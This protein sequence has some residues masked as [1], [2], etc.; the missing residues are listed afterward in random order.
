MSLPRGATPGAVDLLDE[1]LE[2]V[3]RAWGAVGAF[4]L[5]ALPSRVAL[6][7]LLLLATGPGRRWAPLLE[8]SYL[9][10]ALGLL[11]VYGRVALGRALSARPPVPPD[12]WRILAV[13]V[14]A[15]AR[16]L[17]ASLAVVLA[18]MLL[19]FTVLAPLALLPLL[20]LVAV[21]PGERLLTLIS[22]PR[23]LLGLHLLL[24]PGL[25]VVAVN[26]HGVV[27][28][29]AA[30]LSSV[31]PGDPQRLARALVVQ[32]PRYLALLLGGVSLCIEP[33][34]L[35]ALTAHVEAARA[36]T[37]GEDLRVW[38]EE[39]RASSPRRAA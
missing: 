28:L 8:R 36:R 12:R 27:S 29:I 17:T 20:G 6:V 30:A 21:A 39:L 26:L 11:T 14:A 35:G 16:A 34:W 5:L 9:V 19:G 23:R 3:T 32:N 31:L 33:V 25:L 1:G 15:F 22:G 10:L 13:P 7:G 24:V 38:L 37:S 4:W 18:A 2:R